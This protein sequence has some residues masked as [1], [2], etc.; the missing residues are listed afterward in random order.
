VGVVGS[1][2]IA[3][4]LRLWYWCHFRFR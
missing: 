2:V 3:I 4:R 1:D